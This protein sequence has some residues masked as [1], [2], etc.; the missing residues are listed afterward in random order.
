MYLVIRNVQKHAD[1]HTKHPDAHTKSY[2]LTYQKMDK[3]KI[4]L[5]RRDINV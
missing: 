3:N 2:L 5:G 1:K 4:G